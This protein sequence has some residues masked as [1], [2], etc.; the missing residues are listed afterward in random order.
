MPIHSKTNLYPGINAHL[1]SYLQ[2]EG[3]GWES[4]HAEHIID[5]RRVL[6]Q[7]LP[8]GYYAVA[9]KSL[10]IT[11]LTWLGDGGGRTVRP[12]VTVVQKS[13]VS[14]STTPANALL[15]APISVYPGRVLVADPDDEMVGI[16]VYRQ[17]M[18]RL[19]GRPVTRIEL[20]SPANKPPSDGYRQ[21]SSK[22]QQTLESGVVLIEVDYLH[23]TPSA[24]PLIPDYSK[25]QPGA[26]PY[27]ITIDIP[28]PTP[29]D[30][31]VEHYGMGVDEALLTLSVPLLDADFAP[32]DFQEAYTRTIESGSF[33][34]FAIDYDADPVNFDRYREDDQVKIGALLETIRRERG[35]QDA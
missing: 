35:G 30:G 17:E 19:P 11:P 15:A 14:R 9:E 21:Y 16:V 33:F 25:R 4:F 31:K 3:G 28:Q 13:P 34:D 10:Q 18:G 8:E 24:N 20:L 32:L 6:A 29:S 7:T 22:R 26:F 12:D 5:L 1:N 27:N 2:Q 23:Q